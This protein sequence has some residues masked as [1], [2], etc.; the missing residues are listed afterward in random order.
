MSALHEAHSVAPS[1]RIPMLLATLRAG[2]CRIAQQHGDLT[3]T[4]GDLASTSALATAIA[5]SGAELLDAW[6]DAFVGLEGGRRYNLLCASG[7]Q[8][9]LHRTLLEPGERWP[10]IGGVIPAALP[11]ENDLRSAG[12]VPRDL[13]TDREAT[14]GTGVFTIPFGPVRSGVV[15]SVLYQIDTAGE[16]MLL[17]RPQP[18]FKRRGLERRL[19]TVPLDQV[20]LVA[21]RIAGM[22][23]VAGAL[24]VCRAVESIAGVEPTAEA[25]TV[26]LVLAELERIYNHCDSILKLTDDASLVVGTAQMGILKERVMRSLAAL[27]GHRFGRGVVAPGGVQRGLATNDLRDQL[28]R[29]GDDSSRVR[30][31][32]LRT[33]S[34]LDR[35]ERTGGLS[36]EIAAALGGTGPVARGSHLARD[37]RFQRP[38]EAYR[39]RPVEP[40]VM[41]DCDA[42]ARTEVRMA[43]IRASLRLIV[44][45]VED[46]GSDLSAPPPP[47]VD[48]PPHTVGVG[49]V[50][51]PEG[52]WIVVLE[53]GDDGQLVNARVRPASIANFACFQRACEGWVLTDF[54][55]IE[56]SF[57]LAIAGRDR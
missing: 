45:V 41:S 56:H 44:D 53:T 8:V 7:P 20:V 4:A 36:T 51:S 35:L 10:A 13:K 27:T 6:E 16:D 40:A 5:E 22:Y 31:L 11:Y 49:W 19:C 47:Q 14:S 37:A 48:L 54:A 23:S 42:M 17:V 18:G 9:L 50:E 34:F 26:R 46:R 33:D 30:R 2:G 1:Q 29:F 28:R 32:L 25:A 24:A 3:V 57:G 55:F 43:E 52:E 12:G 39:D 15:E 21:E 38:Y